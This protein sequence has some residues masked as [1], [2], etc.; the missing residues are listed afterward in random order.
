MNN[1]RW[2]SAYPYPIQQQAE[3]AQFYP[4]ILEITANI[5]DKKINTVIK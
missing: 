1:A 2:L 4:M 3:I 5:M